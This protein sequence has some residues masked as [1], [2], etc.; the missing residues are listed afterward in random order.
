MNQND[1][2]TVKALSIADG[3]K[4]VVPASASTNASIVA[5]NAFSCTGKVTIDA[6]QVTSTKTDA[7]R[8][9]VVLTVPEAATLDA[10]MFTL[11]ATAAAANGYI[12]VD[13]NGDGT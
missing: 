3:V 8:E 5:T 9:A 1:V 11:D 6:S 2:F 4:I 10:S 12:R 13:V 7:G